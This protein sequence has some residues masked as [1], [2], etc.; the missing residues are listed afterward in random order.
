[1]IDY[2]ELHDYEA[3][4]AAIIRVAAEDYKKAYKHRNSRMRDT[5][6]RAAADQHRL[7]AFFR[8]GWFHFLTDVD[9]DYIMERIKEEVD[10]EWLLR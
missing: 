5:R 9:G 6:E 10:K 8:S 7:E 1:M 3:L 4:A 2:N